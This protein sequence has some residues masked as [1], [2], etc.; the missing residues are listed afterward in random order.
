MN[1]YRNFNSVEFNSYVRFIRE[2][3][4]H[5]ITNTKAK[6]VIRQAGMD[7]NFNVEDVYGYL[8]E[9]TMEKY[10]EYMMKLNKR[11]W[12]DIY[13]NY[14]DDDDLAPRLQEILDMNGGKKDNSFYRDSFFEIIREMGI[15]PYIMKIDMSLDCFGWLNTFKILVEKAEE[16]PFSGDFGIKIFEK[17]DKKSTVKAVKETLE[18]SKGKT[19]KPVGRYTKEDE[20]IKVYSSVKDAVK[21]LSSETGKDCKTANIYQAI[22]EGVTAYGFKWK[23]E[24]TVSETVEISEKMDSEMETSV[25]SSHVS[26]P[27]EPATEIIKEKLE[28]SGKKVSE[29]LVAYY[30]DKEKQLDKDREIGRY[31]SQQDACNSL[32][33]KKSVLSNYL[34]GRKASV[35][36]ITPEGDKVRIGFD[37]IS[38]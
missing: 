15:N 28:K 22:R 5:V 21:E 19:G 10:P 27:V 25:E 14:M 23:Y 34:N 12:R 7:R 16:N 8:H 30:L 2:N 32:G 4:K 18:P 24:M 33:I 3:I 6:Y 29:C 13:D 11:D 38:A 31:T 17:A 9:T 26:T 37:K 1:T 36:F 35:F 20:L